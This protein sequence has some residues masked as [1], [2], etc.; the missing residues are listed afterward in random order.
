MTYHSLDRV[1]L[2]SGNGDAGTALGSVVPDSAREGS[3]EQTA[4]QGVAGVGAGSTG[5]IAA[6]ESSFSGGGGGG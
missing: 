2:G 5:E 1:A 6:V 4:G 3:A